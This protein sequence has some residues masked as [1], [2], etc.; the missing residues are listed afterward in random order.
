[1]SNHLLMYLG[2][3]FH[4]HACACVCAY[5]C[6]CIT[7]MLYIT[8]KIFKTVFRVHADFK[9]SCKGAHNP[10]ASSLSRE[11]NSHNWEVRYAPSSDNIYWFVTVCSIL[12]RLLDSSEIK[13]VCPQ[14]S[15]QQSTLCLFVFHGSMTHE[16]VSHLGSQIS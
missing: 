3:V 13:A 15:Y 9:M 5:V 8:L 4:L 6:M 14:S 1:M 7:V 16:P 10:M 11:L 2:L 12:L